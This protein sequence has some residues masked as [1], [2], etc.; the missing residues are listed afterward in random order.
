MLKRT[1]KVN[2][3]LFLYNY[4]A[5]L[6]TSVHTD[7]HEVTY[8]NK[9]YILKQSYNDL[10]YHTAIYEFDDEPRMYAQIP[11]EYFRVIIDDIKL[12]EHCKPL[13]K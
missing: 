10:S 4:F 3:I 13:F 1:Y 9:N 11:T 12:K 8:N 6:E 5:A 7:P 2:D